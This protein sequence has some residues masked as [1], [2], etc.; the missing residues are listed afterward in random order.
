VADHADAGPKPVSGPRD[1]ALKGSRIASADHSQ[2]TSRNV[3]E[4]NV[5]MVGYVRKAPVF[6]A[7]KVTG[8]PS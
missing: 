6:L 3:P 7:N 5:G 2:R 4:A 1:E 8:V